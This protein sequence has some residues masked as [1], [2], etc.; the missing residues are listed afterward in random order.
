MENESLV[1]SA[2]NKKEIITI[3]MGKKIS[4][5]LNALASKSNIW[6][7]YHIFRKENIL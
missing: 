7:N 1:P 2:Y 4:F 6:Y 5:F 3:E